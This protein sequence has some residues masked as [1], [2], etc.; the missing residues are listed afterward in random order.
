MHLAILLLISTEHLQSWINIHFQYCLAV[1]MST[2]VNP[3]IYND[4][5]LMPADKL[6]TI[7]L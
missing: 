1:F 4:I 5:F 3:V 7:T 6:A 2:E